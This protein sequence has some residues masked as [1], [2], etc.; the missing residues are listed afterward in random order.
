[1][2]I[3]NLY[4][5]LLYFVC[6]H[7]LKMVTIELNN[8]I[9]IIDDFKT[10]HSRAIYLLTHFHSDHYKNIKSGLYTVLAHKITIKLL[11]LKSFF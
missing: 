4:Y 5:N 9:F 2:I 7:A 6:F 8:Q 11:S 1:M 10:V 3:Y